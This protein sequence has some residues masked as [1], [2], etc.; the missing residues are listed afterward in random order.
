[1]L[2]DPSTRVLF[3]GDLFGGLTEKGEKSLAAGEGDWKGIRAFHQIYMPSN[4]ALRRAV[5]AIRRLD[6][7]PEVLAPQHGSI[8]QGAVV[9]EWLDRVYHLPVGLDI[10]DEN[11]DS[12]LDGWN[13]VLARV[14]ELSRALL[15]P[16]AEARLADDRSIEDTLSFEGRELRITS[17]GRFT[18]EKVLEAL[19]RFESPS[20][21]NVL[22]MEAIAVADQLGLPVPRIQLEDA[23]DQATASDPSMLI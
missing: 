20:F 6:P 10:L 1:M 15:G 2:Y 9:D 19:T 13:H 23:G 7:K 5:D 21:A 4:A 17:L 8:A 12:T 3:T 18:M 16:A 14:I 11:D 22:R